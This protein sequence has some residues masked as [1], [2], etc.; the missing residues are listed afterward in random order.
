M[1]VNMW[2]RR[3]FAEREF[4]FEKEN[5]G[6]RRKSRFGSG[7]EE[8]VWGGLGRSIEIVCRR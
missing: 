2:W 7:K 8:E 3:K 5:L 6:K 4:S 1:Y